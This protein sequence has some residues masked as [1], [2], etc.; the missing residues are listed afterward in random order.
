MELTP[1]QV[2]HFQRLGLTAEDALICGVFDITPERWEQGERE[3]E[4]A[5]AKRSQFR[6]TVTSAET[7]KPFF[8]EYPAFLWGSVSYKSDGDCKYP[9]DRGWTWLVLCHW[10][11]DRTLSLS[12]DDGG[13][14]ILIRS[15]HQE[16]AL[17][18]AY[19]TS[20]RAGGRVLST[21]DD[22]TTVADYQT[23]AGDVDERTRRADAVVRKF[24]DADL[25]SYDDFDHF[26]FWKYVDD[27]V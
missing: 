20:L 16:D 25:A 2:A 17:G 14:S 15:S 21:A 27:T 8:A 5:V 18:A 9:T 3:N 11:E 7:I 6:I 24:T 1:E 13:D 4:A 23:V 22:L 12:L 26:R 19:L 10:R